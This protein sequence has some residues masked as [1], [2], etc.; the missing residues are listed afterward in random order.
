MTGVEIPF[1]DVKSVA[2]QVL[3]EHWL[4]YPVVLFIVDRSILPFRKCFYMGTQSFPSL[5]AFH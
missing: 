4:V 5:A 2:Y 3:K 1:S